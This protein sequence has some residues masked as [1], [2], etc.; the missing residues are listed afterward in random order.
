MDDKNLPLVSVPVVTYNSSKTV[1]E[2]LDSIYNQTYP[3]IELIVSDDSSP[4]NTVELVRDWLETHKERFA[5]VE[6][7]TVEKNTGVSANSNRSE[8]ACTG[9]WRKG[10]A[11]DDILLPNCIQDCMDYVTE[12]PD[13]IWLFG[14]MEAFGSTEEENKRVA[15]LF[16]YSFFSKTQEEQLHR[17]IFDGNCIPA[18]A[19]F[20]HIQRDKETGVKNDERIPMME[21]WPKWINLL[22]AGVK[23][24]FI[25]K[26]IVRYRIGG[27]STK[28]EVKPKT[29]RSQRLFYFLYQFPEMY[30]EN[31]DKV[32]SNILDYE[33][34]IFQQYYDRSHCKPYLL[35]RWILHPLSMIKS[36]LKKK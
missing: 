12:H 3:N 10:I 24:H 4:D 33:C 14:K 2:T 19:S 34:E 22:R 13:T 32:L 25:D 6:L 21:D 15:A 20:V 11:G 30:K 1:I 36:I 28:T 5:R 9:V 27:I 18:P 16:D 8:N 17:L 26:T 7:I 31:P 23:L 35:G 29:F